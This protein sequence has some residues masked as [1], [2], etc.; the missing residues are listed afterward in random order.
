MY[1]FSEFLWGCAMSKRRISKIHGPAAYVILYVGATAKLVLASLRCET[2]EPKLITEYSK[3]LLPEYGTKVDELLGDG[4][5]KASSKTKLQKLYSVII[6]AIREELRETPQLIRT[7][8]YKIGVASV[9]QLP[10]A[11]DAPENLVRLW[12][13]LGFI[14]KC[15]QDKFAWRCCEAHLPLHPS[16]KPVLQSLCEQANT[17]GNTEGK[18][19]LPKLPEIF[20]Q[21]NEVI[22]GAEGTTK[23][24]RQFRLGRIGAALRATSMWRDIESRFMAQRI[25]GPYFVYRRARSSMTNS[26]ADIDLI[27][28]DFIW[29]LP[30]PPEGSDSDYQAYGYYFSAFDKE[31]YEIDRVSG[32]VR[33]RSMLKIDATAFRTDKPEK[34]LFLYAPTIPLENT[35]TF[36]LGTITGTLR[37]TKRTGGWTCVIVRPKLHGIELQALNTLIYS[38]VRHLERIHPRN[39][40]LDGPR[41]GLEIDRMREAI[42]A[43]GLAGVYTSRFLEAHD[44]LTAEQDASLAALLPSP[45]TALERRLDVMACFCHD[46]LRQN[47]V[48]DFIK[49]I[50]KKHALG[51]LPQQASEA[52][53][54]YRKVE[55]ALIEAVFESVT[56]STVPTAGLE[57]ISTVWRSQTFRTLYGPDGKLLENSEFEFFRTLVQKLT[58]CSEHETIPMEEYEKLFQA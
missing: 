38:Y 12:E 20:E 41:Y 14:E 32:L 57:E 5:I 9:E 37:D 30:E 50:F 33:P 51:E 35:E 13:L 23:L 16:W 56:S 6:G 24:C 2:A 58:S 54:Y 44:K 21:I 48:H 1:E 53:G 4:Q 26:K 18:N 47:S 31:V 11:D 17:G 34:S 45:Q 28:R 7:P 15:I 3:F 52:E 43:F 36:T 22:A 29:I 10:L 39:A 19:R 25:R 8:I 49:A 27:V 42:E 46:Q 55:K 40:T